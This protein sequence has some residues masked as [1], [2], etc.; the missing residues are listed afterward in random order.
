MGHTGSVGQ[1]REETSKLSDKTPIVQ[2]SI[3]DSIAMIE[4]YMQKV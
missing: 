1:V 3:D 4:S 2:V